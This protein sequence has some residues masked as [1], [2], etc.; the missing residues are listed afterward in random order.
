[1][2]SELTPANPF[3]GPTLAS[4]FALAQAPTPAPDHLFFN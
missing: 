1:M 4:M 3:H 2:A